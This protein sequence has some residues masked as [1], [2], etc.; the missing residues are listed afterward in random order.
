MNA[1]EQRRQ[2]WASRIVNY[3][4]SGLTIAAWCEAN[5]CTVEQMKY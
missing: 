4:A 2:E 3:R 5:H 1:K